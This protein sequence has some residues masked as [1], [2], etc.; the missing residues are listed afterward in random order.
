[1]SLWAKTKTKSWPPSMLS[2]LTH[3]NPRSRSSKQTRIL[4]FKE[5]LVLPTTKN[6]TQSAFN[7]A[8][9][10]ILINF[11]NLKNVKSAATISYSKKFLIWSRRTVILKAKHG[12]SASNAV[13]RRIRSTLCFA[14]SMCLSA[15]KTMCGPIGQAASVSRA[16]Q[17]YL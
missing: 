12:W 13:W 4:W 2:K 15:R 6:L 7:A 11:A 9:F 14:T 1:M 3:T 8:L 5:S 17:T 10:S 16:R